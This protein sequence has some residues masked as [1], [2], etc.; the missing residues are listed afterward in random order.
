MCKNEKIPSIAITNRHQ[1]EGDYLEQIKIVAKQRPDS[2]I[3]R[4]KDLPANEYEE[5]AKQVIPIGKKYQVPVFLHYY[6][7]VAKKLGVTNIHVPFLIL[8]NMTSKEKDLFLQIGASIHSVEEAMEAQKQ[9]ATR[10]IAGHIFETS[11]KP[12][13]SPRGLDFLRKVCQSVT[14]P[15]YAIGGITDKNAK[16]CIMAGTKGV[17]MMSAFMKKDKQF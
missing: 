8:Q 13:L 5:L 7:D 10:L 1:V 6:V 16:E 3:L 11:C 12:G 2:I 4:E 9:G 17:C 14:I 15:V